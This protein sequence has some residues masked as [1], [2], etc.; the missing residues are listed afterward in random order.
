MKILVCGGRAYNNAK[1]VFETLRALDPKPTLLINGGAPGADALAREWAIANNVAV[2]TFYANWAVYGRAAGP[3]RN[4][5]M[6]DDGKPELVIAF[7]GHLGT[8]DMCKRAR[9][10]GIKVV[11]HH[12]AY[13]PIKIPPMRT[14]L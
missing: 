13:L 9:A 12:G 3:I 1:H 2:Q 6:I 11:E 7:P 14:G 8:I 10:C 4:Q 5:K